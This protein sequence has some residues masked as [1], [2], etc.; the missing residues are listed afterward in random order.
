MMKLPFILFFLL[1]D[2][3]FAVEPKPEYQLELKVKQL[4][5][6]ILNCNQRALYQTFVPVFRREVEFSRFDSAF[7]RWLHGR[8]PFRVMSKVVEK[9]GLG[10]YVSTYVYFEGEKDYEYLYHSWIYTDSG[11]EL[12]WVSG[13]LNQSFLYGRSETLA[14]RAVAQAALEFFLSPE[15]LRWLRL[16]KIALPETIVVV[17]RGRI[18]EGAM[19]ISGHTAL[20]QTPLVMRDKP[21]FPLMPLYC[22]FGMVRVFGSVALAV[23]DFKSWPYYHGRRVL[24]RPR[25]M[26]IYLKKQGE[27]WQVSSV[28]KVW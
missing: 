16:G 17:Q 13:L 21:A 5:E 18:E 14:M 11:W 24:K 22:E 9:R 1:S 19:V 23:L 15:G 10:G 20:W 2:L 4:G 25:G 7:D 26:E 6:A 12:A 3:T 8:R 28:G 27:E